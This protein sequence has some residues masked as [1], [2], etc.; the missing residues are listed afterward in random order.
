MKPNPGHLPPEARGRRVRVRL[1]S[2]EI[3][4][5]PGWP[6]DGPG[7]CRWTLA[8]QPYDIAAYEVLG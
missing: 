8:G 6:A 2:G 7:G 5:A 1:A 3:V 4:A